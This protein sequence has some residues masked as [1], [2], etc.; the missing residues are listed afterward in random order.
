MT[1]E[2]ALSP[3]KGAHSGTTESEGTESL[4]AQNSRPASPNG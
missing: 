3:S 2:P 1:E 4:R